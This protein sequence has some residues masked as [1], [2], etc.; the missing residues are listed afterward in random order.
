MIFLLANTFWKSF[1][2]VALCHCYW[3]MQKKGFVRFST[4]TLT[5]AKRTPWTFGTLLPFPFCLYLGTLTHNPDTHTITHKF[6]V[7]HFPSTNY[8]KSFLTQP[9]TPT[10]LWSHTPHTFPSCIAFC[11]N[12]YCELVQPNCSNWNVTSDLN[13]NFKLFNQKK[14]FFLIDNWKTFKGKLLSRFQESGLEVV[15]SVQVL[16]VVNLTDCTI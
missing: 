8:R 7:F 6:L 3:I 11:Q 15:D 12:S 13:R 14:G 2:C 10:P 5:E 4:R 9:Q 16:H 1:W